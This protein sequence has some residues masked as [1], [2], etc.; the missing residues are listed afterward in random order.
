M[1]TLFIF[2][3]QGKLT[4]SFPTCSALLDSAKVTCVSR[5]QLSLLDGPSVSGGDWDWRYTTSAIPLSNN[6]SFLPVSQVRSSRP[7]AHRRQA[8]G[9]H[10]LASSSSFD[11]R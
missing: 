11:G 6:S 8:R 3:T 5:Y 4:F 1:P 7:G 2:H 9:D 10:R